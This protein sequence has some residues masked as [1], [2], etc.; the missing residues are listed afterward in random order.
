MMAK[1]RY[2]SPARRKSSTGKKVGAAVG[3]ILALAVVAGV[4]CYFAIPEVNTF[5]NNLFTPK[6]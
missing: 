6:Q 5:V 2:K 1:K 3:I 4:I